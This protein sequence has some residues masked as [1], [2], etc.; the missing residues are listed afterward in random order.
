M[1]KFIALILSTVL[2]TGCLPADYPKEIAVYDFNTAVIQYE[3][4][5]QEEG[6]MTLYMRGDQKATYKATQTGNTLELNLGNKAYLVDMDKATAVESSTDFY[7]NLKNLSKEEQNIAIIKKALGLKDSA[8]DPEA[9]T[10]KVVAGQSCDVYNIPNIGT[11]CIWNGIVL[12]K[13]ITMLGLVNKTVAVS[14]QTNV[15]IP[16]ERFELPANV[17]VQ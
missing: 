1:K 4:T 11:A 14:V 9:V 12:E 2:L 6:D 5:G 16:P 7:A 15:D 8:D 17:I 13:E 10:R 3:L